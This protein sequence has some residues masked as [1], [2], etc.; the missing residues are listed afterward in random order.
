M[1]G[2]QGS[3]TRA[4]EADTSAQLASLD[5]PT[6]ALAQPKLKRGRRSGAAAESVTFVGQ[7]P[8]P[9]VVPAHEAAKQKPWYNRSYGKP[10][11]PEA[12]MA[13]SRQLASFMEAGISILEALEIVAEETSS[14]EM[15]AV[16]L[17]IRDTVRRGASFADA[18]GKHVKVF[19][20]YYRAMVVSAEFTGR[21]DQVMNQLATY[22][23]RDIA[24]KRQIRSALTYPV[25]ILIVAA[26][27]M[28]VM[29]VFVLPKFSGL[30]R[31]LGAKLPLPTR[32][33]LGFTDF[34]GA[35]WPMVF[36]G[37]G[38]LLMLA[39]MVIGGQ[40]NKVRRDKMTM[41]LPVIGNLFHLISIER[42][43]RVL[44]ALATAGVPLP[45]AIQV[46][47]DCTN[48]SIFRSRMADVR[49]TL[50]RGGGLSTPMVETGL[51]PI[52][53]RQMIRVGER[54]GSLG[55]QLSKAAS[56]YEREVGFQMK[57]ATDMFQPTIILLV[58]A[59][60][61]FVAVAQVSAMYSIFGQVR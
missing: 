23:E 4:V 18:V 45:D 22:M 43:C 51:F 32:L 42:F 33:L 57:R 60:V 7:A 24:A 12:V 13:F 19:P 58:G 21:L 54:T 38:M 26:L 50:T 30:Y 31:S 6:P 35:Y 15:R 56:Y 16:I 2:N 49:E 14:D 1:S 5:S 40:R 47:A 17:E 3:A 39:S 29:A 20:A 37:I 27:A 55:P 11:K 52:A 25:M 10:V 41:R 59:L 61:G 34:M 48:N 53:A 44:S 28:V 36:G 8:K 9:T 46:S